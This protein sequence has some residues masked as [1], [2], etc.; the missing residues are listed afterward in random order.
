[1]ATNRLIPD[2]LTRWVL[3]NTARH[4]SP[5]HAPISTA[6]WREL[7][8]ND[9]VIIQRAGELAIPASIDIVAPSAGTIWVWQDRGLGRIA[10][11]ESDD[12]QVWKRTPTTDAAERAPLSADDIQGP[13]TPF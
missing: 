7:N 3:S 12:V 2:P 6:D 8:P 4:D 13:T 11:H 9:P 1:M 5:A 10:I